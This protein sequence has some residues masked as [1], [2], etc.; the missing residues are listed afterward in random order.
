MKRFLLLFPAFFLASCDQKSPPPPPKPLPVTVAQPEK[1]EVIVYQEFPSTLLGSAEIE[2]NARVA[3]ILSLAPNAPDFAGQRVE[4]GT[5]LFVIE[6]ETYQQQTRSAQAALERNEAARNLAQK[7]F[8]RI[9]RASKTNAVSEIDVEIASAELAETEAAIAQARAELERARINESYTLIT[10][11]VTGRMSRLLIDP[12]NLVGTAGSTLLATIIDDSV[13]HAYFEVPERTAIQY[14]EVRDSGKADQ[15]YQKGIR[16]KL[17]D[18]SIFPTSGQID[19][20]ENKINPATRTIK[21][22]ALFQN[23]NGAL[24]SGLYGLVGYPTGPEPGKPEITEATLVPSVAILRDLGGNF[25]WVVDEKNIVRRQAIEAGDAVE[26]PLNDP[27]SPRIL[28][29]IIKKGLTGKERVIVSGLQRAREGAPV[30]PL[31]AEQ[32]QSR[33]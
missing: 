1:R 32:A 19:Y 25:V 22:R 9:E 10:A 7:R 17:A 26:K 12:G 33:P 27:N 15:V 11:P 13:M 2:I 30:T 6:P 20:I 21:V 23:P 3:G 16:L 28:E 5:P 31:T 18:Q 24:S 4:K 29:T 8:D 14:F